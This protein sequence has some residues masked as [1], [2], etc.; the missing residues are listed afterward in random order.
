VALEEDAILSPKFS[1]SDLC[2]AVGDRCRTCD[3]QFLQFG[4]RSVF[5]GRIHTVE[6]L[7]DNILLRSMLESPCDGDVLVVDGGGDLS[8]ALLGDVI[9]S[10]GARNGWSGVV[11]HG[12]IRD[13]NALA[14]LNFGVKALG[15]NPR[16]SA[17]HGAGAIDIPV[18][19]GGVTFTP[20][21]WIYSDSDGILV[22]DES[23]DYLINPIG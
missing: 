1:T 8:C 23:L 11:I 16:K 2:D 10:L 17:K 15:T 20:N 21:H 9:G 18:S 3:L 13:V 4:G 12:A 14:L 5:S 22:S 6:C 7:R 19:F